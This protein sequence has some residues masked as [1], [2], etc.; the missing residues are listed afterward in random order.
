MLTAPI[1]TRWNRS[2]AIRQDVDA[3]MIDGTLKCLRSMLMT[4]VTTTFGLMPL[5][6][7]SNVG[8]DMSARIMKPVVG[9]LWFCMFLTPLGTAGGL[10]HLVSFAVQRLRA[11]SRRPQSR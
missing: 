4:M 6:W 5:L 8:T 2:P 3:A 11:P 1:V 7:K 10:C 9:R